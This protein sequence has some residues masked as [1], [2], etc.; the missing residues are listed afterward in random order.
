M[1]ECRCEKWFHPKCIGVDETNEILL[2]QYFFFCPKCNE[3]IKKE[4]GEKIYQMFNQFSV[5]KVKN[6]KW[7]LKVPLKKILEDNKEKV[8]LMKDFKK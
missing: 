6:S 4:Y 2:N 8:M 3:D 1:I 7:D 5:P